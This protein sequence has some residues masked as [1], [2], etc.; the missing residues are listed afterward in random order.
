METVPELPKNLGARLEAEFMVLAAKLFDDMIEHFLW[1]G[2]P[3]ESPTA[4]KGIR[5]SQ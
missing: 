1:R 4:F 3:V 5:E 2:S